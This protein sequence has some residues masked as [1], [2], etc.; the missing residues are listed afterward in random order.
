MNEGETISCRH[1]NAMTIL[2]I[3]D[4]VIIETVDIGL[5]TIRIHVHV[6]HK[7]YNSPSLSL[8]P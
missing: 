7:M 4:I 1:E 2:S 6:S 5:Q 8:S 3:P